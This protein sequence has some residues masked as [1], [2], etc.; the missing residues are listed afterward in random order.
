MLG[1][2]LEGLVDNENLFSCYFTD[3]FDFSGQF[4]L[5]MLSSMLVNIPK[6]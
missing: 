5:A 1:K 6:Q 4:A 2:N 3:N